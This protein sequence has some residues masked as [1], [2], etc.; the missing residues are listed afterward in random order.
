MIFMNVMKTNKEVYNEKST[1][2]SNT[3]T[4]T[5]SSDKHLL[6]LQDSKEIVQQVKTHDDFAIGLLRDSFLNLTKMR[7]GGD[8][9]RD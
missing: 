2:I 6:L 5:L 7:Y 3:Y 8:L 4:H 9:H 1:A